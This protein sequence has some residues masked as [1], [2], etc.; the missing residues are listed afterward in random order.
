[1]P[2]QVTHSGGIGFFGLLTIVFI[3]L[4]LLGYIEWS[5]V[6]VLSPIWAPFLLILI[7]GIPLTLILC[8]TDRR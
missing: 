6:W 8:W 3:T 7:I 1:M 4:K 2:E 5:W